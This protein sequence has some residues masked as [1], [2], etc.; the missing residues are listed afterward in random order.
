MRVHTFLT[1]NSKLMR[2]GIANWIVVVESNSDSKFDRRLT[3]IRISTILIES[4]IAIFDINR[5]KINLFSVK[6]IFFDIKLSF[7]RLKS[8]KCRL[9]NQNWSNYIKHGQFWSCLRYKLSFLIKFDKFLIKFDKFLIKSNFF[10]IFESKF[11]SKS[12]RW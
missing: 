12:S 3:S 9:F 7:N 6:S 4:T 5:Y 1:L 8:I 11:E 10:N 2:L